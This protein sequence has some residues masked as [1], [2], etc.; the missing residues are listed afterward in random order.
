MVKACLLLGSNLG[1][2]EENLSAARGLIAL[3]SGCISKA[4]SLYETAPWGNSQQPPFLNQALVVETELNARQLLRR[5]LRIEKLMGR[6]RKEKFGPRIID[7]DILLFGEE[8]HQYPLLQI[9]HPELPNRRFALEPLAEIAPDIMHP[10]AHQS[11]VQ[12]LH[13]C[14]DHLPVKK[15]S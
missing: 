13:E 4:S 14:Q 12:L 9:P 11:I 1:N 15:V 2:R 8:V 10:L 6:V 7:I 5:V 3:N